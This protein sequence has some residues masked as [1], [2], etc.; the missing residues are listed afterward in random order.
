M[1]QAV[2]LTHSQLNCCTVRVVCVTLSHEK[3][4]REEMGGDGQLQIS[5]GS[6]LIGK[7]AE[8]CQGG[9]GGGPLEK[10]PR[11]CGSYVAQK[12]WTPKAPCKTPN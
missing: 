3:V 7:T 5:L 11:L 4:A 9:G 12:A 2:A 10:K 6:G 1:F 8:P